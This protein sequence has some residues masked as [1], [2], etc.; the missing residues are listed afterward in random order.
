M[1][2][3]V[4]TLASHLHRLMPPLGPE[5]LFKGTRVWLRLRLPIPRDCLRLFLFR[6]LGVS[7][8][9]L[10]GAGTGAG[11]VGAGGGATS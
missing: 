2:Q 3:L 5:L 11:G 6:I 1:G 4:V 7:F 10:M 9:V 8:L